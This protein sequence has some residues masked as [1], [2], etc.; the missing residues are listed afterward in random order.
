MFLG[1]RTESL[2]EK[3]DADL[4]LHWVVFCKTDTWEYRLSRIRI[5]IDDGIRNEPSVQDWVEPGLVLV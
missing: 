2:S 1:K 5:D 3:I 4:E